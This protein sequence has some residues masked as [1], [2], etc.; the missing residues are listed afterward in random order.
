MTGFIVDP[1]GNWMSRRQAL[2]RV[3]FAG[4]AGLSLPVS[5]APA[6]AASHSAVDL[7]TA[8]GFIEALIKL[9]ADTGGAETF[10]GF[11]GQVWAW[12]PGEGNYHVFNSYGIGAS[13]VE[14][15]PDEKAWR[16]YHREALL[17]L[18]PETNDV[19]ESWYN[20]FT[21][22]RVEVLPILN[23]HVNRYYELENSFL[24][25]PWP[26]EIH[27]DDLVTQI[28][29]FRIEQNVM[30]RD[31]YPL[32][33]QDETYQTCELWGFIGRLGE[34]MNP[35]TTSAGCVTSWCRIGPWLPFM[36]MGNRPGQMVYHSHSYKFPD[37]P[38]ELPKHIYDWFETNAP[39]YFRSPRV[40][41]DP[42]QRAQSDNSWGYSKAFIDDK[43][44]KGL[45]EG[46]TPFQWTGDRN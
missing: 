21:E 17:Y 4:A 28:S 25:F 14:W 13:R 19:L 12:I 44:K 29:V 36:E 27:G 46:R 15:R 3:A 24:P 39:K 42:A 16:Y 18:D 31:E 40:W 2:G 5:A 23:D 37:G 30:S 43:R 10:G 22:R 26:Y 6:R 8:E 33:A 38:S 7:D 1:M 32:H 35:D 41:T 34:V 9:Q 11:P 45:K 20:P